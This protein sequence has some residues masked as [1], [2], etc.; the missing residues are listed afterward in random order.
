MV[1]DNVKMVIETIISVLT[2][3]YSSVTGKKTYTV[4]TES[5]EQFNNLLSDR[6]KKYRARTESDE[7]TI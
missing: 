2:I 3:T 7:H 5:D 6:Q 1:I 4:R